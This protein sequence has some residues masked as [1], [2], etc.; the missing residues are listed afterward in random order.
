M[1]DARL[2]LV[3]LGQREHLVGH[4]EAVRLAG[5]ADAAR[6]QQHIDAAAGAE[7]EHDLA[8]V[9]LCER[10]GVSAP[11]RREHR[12]SRDPDAWS[13]SYRFEVTGSQQATAAASG[14]PHPHPPD[15]PSVT[16]VACLP[17]RRCTSSLIVSDMVVSL[18]G[19]AY[20]RVFRMTRTIASGGVTPV[21][22]QHS[23]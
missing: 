9:Q 15:R 7:I 11:E 10:G 21:P 18:V 23:V 20:V 3:L 22:P 8:G 17:Y 12:L 4:V 2:A 19:R 6:G 13:G 5:R 1:V 14:D 16:A